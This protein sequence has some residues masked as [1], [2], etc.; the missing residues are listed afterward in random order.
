[1]VAGG[2]A[3]NSVG[4]DS[5]NDEK[6][7]AHSTRDALAVLEI[8]CPYTRP[9]LPATRAKEHFPQIQVLLQVFG[10]D[11]CHFV[12]Y[13]PP[14]LGRGRAGVMNGDR[15]LYLRETV[16][17][18]DGWWRANKPRLERFH[19][20]LS[21]AIGEREARLAF[22]DRGDGGV[23]EDWREDVLANVDGV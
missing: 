13:K 3:R 1:V 8:K 22:A 11:E 6:K 23:V 2:T 7:K 9:V 14:G 21:A 15:P 18:D 12:Q 5:G 10:A 17:R 19:E 16:A 4:A 20:A